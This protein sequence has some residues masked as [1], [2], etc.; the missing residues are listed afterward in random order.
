MKYPV[1]SAVTVM[2]KEEFIFFNTIVVL[3][4]GR[5]DAESFT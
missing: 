4:S 3:A 1:L 2:L 5:P